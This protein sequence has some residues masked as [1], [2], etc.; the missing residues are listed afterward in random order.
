MNGFIEGY[1]GP[2]RS[3]RCPRSEESRTGKSIS[4]AKAMEAGTAK[5]LTRRETRGPTESVMSSTSF[6]CQTFLC[7]QTYFQTDRRRYHPRPALKMELRYV[8]S[9]ERK[10]PDSV[11]PPAPFSKRPKPPNPGQ[12]HRH[13]PGTLSVTCRLIKG[14]MSELVVKLLLTSDHSKRRKLPFYIL[15]HLLRR[16][17][18][19]I[20]IRMILFA[21]FLY[22]RFI[23][24][25]SASLEMPSTS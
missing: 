9:P 21:N 18:A 16:L 22:A 14:S 8:P 25:A 12:N 15:K 19:R 11:C 10:D 24:A 2:P 17:I 5:A 1:L 7:R 20:G 3:D 6:R 23:A 13:L 4:A